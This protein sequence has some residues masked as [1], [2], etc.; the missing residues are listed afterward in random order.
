LFGTTL[1]AAKLTPSEQARSVEM[2]K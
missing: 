2:D 1:C